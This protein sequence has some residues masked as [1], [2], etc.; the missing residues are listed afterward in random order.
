MDDLGIYIQP[1]SINADSLNLMHS[2]FKPDGS[3]F[4]PLILVSC[5]NIFFLLFFARFG[6]QFLLTL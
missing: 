2:F 1:I 3:N 5:V 4:I 6:F